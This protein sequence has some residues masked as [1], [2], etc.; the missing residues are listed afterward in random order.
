MAQCLMSTNDVTSIR[1]A[2]ANVSTLMIYRDKERD[3]QGK[4]ASL[5]A[6][7]VNDRLAAKIGHKTYLTAAH[8]LARSSWNSNCQELI[9]ESK[10]IFLRTYKGIETPRI[11]RM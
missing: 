2:Y 4:V 8:C 11:S 5:V 7:S 3:T 9:S 6:N 1:H 10:K